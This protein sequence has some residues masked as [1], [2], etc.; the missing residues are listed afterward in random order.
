MIR[1]KVGQVTVVLVEDILRVSRLEH[2]PSL[3]SHELLADGLVSLE[4]DRV[5][6]LVADKRICCKLNSKQFFAKK[7]VYDTSIRQISTQDEHY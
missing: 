2:K 3:D 4:E 6:L 1:E 7:A 5:S